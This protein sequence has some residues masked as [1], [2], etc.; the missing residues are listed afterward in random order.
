MD[1]LEM[2]EAM[3]LLFTILMGAFIIFWVWVIFT[4]VT[5]ISRISWA[6]QEKAEAYTRRARAYERFVNL[7]CV[8]YDESKEVDYGYE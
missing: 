4:V 6:A 7:Q 3:G 5:A 2:I 1:V 8:K